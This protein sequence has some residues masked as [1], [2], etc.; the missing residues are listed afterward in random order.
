MINWIGE[1]ETSQL[2]ILEQ[3]IVD[4][5]IARICKRMKDGVDVCDAKS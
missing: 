2:L 1:I 3:I 4:H 5:E